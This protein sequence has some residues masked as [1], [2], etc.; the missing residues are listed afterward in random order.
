MAKCARVSGVTKEVAATGSS[1]SLILFPAAAAAPDDYDHASA[2][3]L[4][5]RQLA[6][7]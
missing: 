2:G 4:K 5:R 7:P 3:L 6:V 1:A